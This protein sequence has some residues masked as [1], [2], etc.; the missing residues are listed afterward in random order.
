M[1]IGK[2]PAHRGTLPLTWKSSQELAAVAPVSKEETRASIWTPAGVART[3]LDDV[4]RYSVLRAGLKFSVCWLVSPEHSCVVAKRIGNSSIREEVC[5]ASK[6]RRCR[7]SRDSRKGG[8]S[9]DRIIPWRGEGVVGLR[10]RRGAS[11]SAQAAAKST[12][13][14]SRLIQAPKKR[15]VEDPRIQAAVQVMSSL[16]KR[17]ERDA[18]DIFGEHV[19]AKH[20]TYNDHIRS[21]VEHEIGHISFNADMGK[22]NTLGSGP[23]SACHTSGI[24]LDIAVFEILNRN[25]T[26]AY[27]SPV[28]T[29]RSV[30]LIFD[31]VVL[32]RDSLQ[33]GMGV[34]SL[35]GH[36]A[37]KQV[38]HDA[39]YPQSANFALQLTQNSRNFTRN[40]SDGAISEDRTCSIFLCKTTQLRGTNNVIAHSG[41]RACGR[42]IGDCE[43]QSSEEYD[44]RLDY[45]TGCVSENIT[46]YDNIQTVFS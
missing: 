9:H 32:L 24:I 44:C 12:P 6:S 42:K 31:E 7:H 34:G 33:A 35:G 19:A 5:E 25:I 18:S 38:L 46:I 11:E 10:L 4:T 15:V 22:Y 45:W 1:E 13:G 30:P 3:T 2:T 39:I 29:Y 41:V 28:A 20:R 17:K 43:H 40:A 26:L 8:R 37:V 36:A 27:E 14:T 21:V 16:S 23:Q